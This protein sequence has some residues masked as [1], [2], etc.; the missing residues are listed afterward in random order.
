MPP[1]RNAWRNSQFENGWQGTLLEEKNRR[2]RDED[3]DV[4]QN[5][6]VIRRMINWWI[7]GYATGASIIIQRLSYNDV[8]RMFIHNNP[9]LDDGNGNWRETGFEDHEFNAGKI[10]NEMKETMMNLRKLCN[11]DVINPTYSIAGYFIPELKYLQPKLYT[12]IKM[13]DKGKGSMKRAGLLTMM[14]FDD[15]VSPETR[16]RAEHLRTM[17]GLTDEDAQNLVKQTAKE[18]GLRRPSFLRAC[19]NSGQIMYLDIVCSLAKTGSGKILVAR[20][21]YDMISSKKITD[22][23]AAVLVTVVSEPGENLMKHFGFKTCYKNVEDDNNIHWMFLKLAD[24][25]FD[26]ISQALPHEGLQRL[27]DMCLRQ[28]LTEKTAHKVMMHGCL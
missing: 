13:S 15:G 20:A 8:R 24:V 4:G 11:N 17:F 3:E 6:T 26:T 7:R 22:E 14:T 28:G 16:D 25:D 1:A 12:A 18:M 23:N 10:S 19:I 27:A 21:L 5:K 2:E 9:L